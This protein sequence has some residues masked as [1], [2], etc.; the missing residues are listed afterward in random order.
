M[1]SIRHKIAVIFL[2]FYISLILMSLF[3]IGFCDENLE[4]KMRFVNGSFGDTI[5][6]QYFGFNEDESYGTLNTRHI[7]K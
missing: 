1:A 5:V 7:C 3:H 4:R 6:V 2:S